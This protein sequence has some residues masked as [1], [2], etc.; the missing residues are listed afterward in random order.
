[1]RN[2][3]YGMEEGVFVVK[4]GSLFAG[5]GGIDLGLERA[6]MTCA[7]QVEI[8]D[9]CNKV[10][11][12]HWPDVPRY[13]DVCTVTQLPY[14]DLI[15]GGFPCPPVS[16]AASFRRKFDDDE[17]WLWPEFYRIICET[18][19]R[20]ALVENVRGLLSARDG[21]LFAGILRDLAQLGYD[22]EWEML[23]ASTFGAPHHRP[24]VFVLAYP[25]GVT[26]R[27]IMRGEWLKGEGSKA[28]QSNFWESQPEPPRMAYGIPDYMDR[29]FPIG[30]AVVPQ[31][32]E[33]IGRRIM[34]YDRRHNE[35]ERNY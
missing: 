29:N 1:M 21:K 13:R 12:K 35:T 14:V 33:W 15:A 28:R 31:V 23:P 17:R 9:Y 8:D 32:V 4:F 27:P 3:K 2:T 30:N 11:E 16:I 5:I 7:W 25:K 20:Y 24:R 22:A 6:G 26:Q 18:K 34:D 10:L 19:P